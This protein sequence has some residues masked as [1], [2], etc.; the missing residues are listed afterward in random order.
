MFVSI[1]KPL[2]TFVFVEQILVIATVEKGV[3][4]ELFGVLI[5]GFVLVAGTMGV[6]LNPAV[7]FSQMIGRSLNP[8][9]TFSQMICRSFFRFL[10]D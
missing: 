10:V 5:G 7:T 4:K 3:L 6:S 8:A 1:Q 2:V 9:V